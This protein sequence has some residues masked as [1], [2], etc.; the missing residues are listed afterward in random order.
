M[1]LIDLNQHI[2]VPI[3]DDHGE[4]TVEI[5]V[6]EFFK[7]F[8]PGEQLKVVDAIPVEW[9]RRQYHKYMQN[10]DKLMCDA[11]AVVIGEWQ[12]WK[13]EQEAR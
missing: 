12:D 7:R 3:T 4:Y 1:K 11:Y 13:N 10:N 5:T 2:T 9:L 6:G 8:L